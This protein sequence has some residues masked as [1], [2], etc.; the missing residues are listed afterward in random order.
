MHPCH[1]EPAL[2]GEVEPGCGRPSPQA[3][4]RSRRAGEGTLYASDPRV[5][6]P[7]SGFRQQALA[8]LTP[9]KRLN[10]ALPMNKPLECTEPDTPNFT[11]RE[12][13]CP[14]ISSAYSARCF[15]GNTFLAYA[16]LAQASSHRKVRPWKR[17]WTEARN[18]R[19]SRKETTSFWSREHVHETFSKNC[20]LELSVVRRC[21]PGL[22]SGW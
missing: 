20:H 10:F 3:K 16:F 2:A 5:P 19:G 6:S 14:L 8:S 15:A 11:R 4:S 22:C 12:F 21:Q 18:C 17:G 1:S 13:N 7:R 9:A